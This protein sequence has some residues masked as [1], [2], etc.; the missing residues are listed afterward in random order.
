MMSL[1]GEAAD[2]REHAGGRDRDRLGGDGRSRRI[3]EDARRPD[4]VLVVQERLAHPHEDRAPHRMVRLGGDQPVLRQDLPG[5]QAANPAQAPGRAE[6]AGERAPDLRAEAD[7]VLR[8]RQ[9]LQPGGLTGPA[10]LLEGARVGR[11]RQRDPHRLDGV[12]VGGPKQVLHES[13]GGPSPLDDLEVGPFAGALQRRGRGMREATHRPGREPGG[14][15]A[16]H[17]RE[18]PL[19]QRR[20]SRREA[21]GRPPFRRDRGCAGSAR[22]RARVAHRS[23]HPAFGPTS[24]W[25]AD[26]NFP[27]HWTSSLRACYSLQTWGAGTE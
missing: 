23:T 18:D 14:A 21:P 5:L 25:R 10:P 26:G 2:R 15:E 9:R 24:F 20:G 16:M 3:A 22:A 1:G 7:G 27:V 13:V 4:D 12:T 19:H 17:A 8:G 11:V 6:V